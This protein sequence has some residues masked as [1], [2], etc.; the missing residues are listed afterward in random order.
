MG[1]LRRFSL[2][3]LLVTAGGWAPM[4]CPSDDYTPPPTM[5]D[6]GEELYSLA[7]RFRD[8]GDMTAWRGTLEYL[9]E[10]CADSR[11]AASAR[12]DIEE[13]EARN[14]DCGR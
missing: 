14:A 4:Q 11:Y 2:V 10:R 7:G 1:A 9:I 6:A 3:A 12:V 5:P 8:R 13:C